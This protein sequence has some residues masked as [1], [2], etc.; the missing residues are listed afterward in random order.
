[1]AKYSRV[2][3]VPRMILQVLEIRFPDLSWIQP[4]I[5]ARINLC[6]ARFDIEAEHTKA[7]PTILVASVEGYDD[8]SGETTTET[9]WSRNLSHISLI[10]YPRHTRRSS[11]CRSSRWPAILLQDH[12]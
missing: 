8:K 2:S 9:W 6:E 3:T 12:A 10:Y 7:G 5:V 1:M 4:K 11:R